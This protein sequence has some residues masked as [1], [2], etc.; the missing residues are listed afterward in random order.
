LFLF[1]LVNVFPGRERVTG[2]DDFE[3]ALI[4]DHHWTLSNV[5]P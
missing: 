1:Q 3:T 2:V 4:Q 5:P